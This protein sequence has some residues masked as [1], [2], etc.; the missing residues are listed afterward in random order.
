ME[1]DKFRY[2]RVGDFSVKAIETQP[3]F[4]CDR[5]FVEQL[6]S[7]FR[8]SV[9]GVNLESLGCRDFV[10][11]I[12]SRLDA[13]CIAYNSA[14]LALGDDPVQM[15]RSAKKSEIKQIYQNLEGLS[16]RLFEQLAWLP[17]EVRV[18]CICD[19][20][21]DFDEIKLK[22]LL[23]RL[24]EFSAK[25][26]TNMQEV[27]SSAGRPKTTDIN[28]LVISLGDLYD[29]HFEGAGTQDRSGFVLAVTQCLRSRFPKDKYKNLTVLTKEK[30]A[31]MLTPKNA[32]GKIP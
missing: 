8:L 9:R 29:S 22:S 23:Q 17:Q 27:K 2:H 31:D 20:Q 12:Q 11:Y 14:Y 6:V 26:L 13:I 15:Y 19:E 24:A 25:K 30:I 10:H 4:Y 1:K 16:S 3:I 28:G 5:E 18:D 21:L 32:I 7:R